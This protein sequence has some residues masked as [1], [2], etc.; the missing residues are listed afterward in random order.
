[1]VLSWSVAVAPTAGSALAAEFLALSDLRF[2]PMA[3]PCLV[4]RPAAR[5]RSDRRPSMRSGDKSL[6]RYGD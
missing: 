5:S 3:D 4:D 1:L 2:N 6:G